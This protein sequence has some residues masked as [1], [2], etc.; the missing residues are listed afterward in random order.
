MTELMVYYICVMLG[1][2]GG[3][4]SLAFMIWCMVRY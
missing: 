2:V 3:M 4:W 1:V